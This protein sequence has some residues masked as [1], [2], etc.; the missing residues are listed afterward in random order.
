MSSTHIFK[1]K[2]F[3]TSIW[4]DW[5]VQVLS[6]KF[7]QSGRY[8]RIWILLRGWLYGR[9]RCLLSR[10]LVSTPVLVQAIT[11]AAAAPEEQCRWTMSTYRTRLEFPKERHVFLL[12]FLPDH[13]CASRASWQVLSS[14]GRGSRCCMS[15]LDC[16]AAVVILYE[17][18]RKFCG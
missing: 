11:L 9:V 12:L 3:I 7:F 13:Q 8:R 14:P 6:Q 5:T 10:G 2:E 18:Q 4:S 17:L 15:V 1:P 16:G